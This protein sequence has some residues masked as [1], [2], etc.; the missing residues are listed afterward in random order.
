MENVGKQRELCPRPKSVTWG[1]GSLQVPLEMTM[2]LGPGCSRET[3]TIMRDSWRHFSYE[4]GHLEIIEDT[5]QTQYS[6]ATTRKTPPKLTLDYNVSINDRGV[7]SI[8]IDE[9]NLLYGW[10]TLLQLLHPN[11]DTVELTNLRLPYVEIADQVDMQT[12]LPAVVLNREIGCQ[13]SFRAD[14]PEMGKTHS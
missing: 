7:A 8:A 14:R 2:R 3:K 13:H 11:N 6:L 4:Q 12:A 1:S 9:K 10:F 5:S